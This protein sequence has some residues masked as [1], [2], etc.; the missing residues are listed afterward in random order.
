[1][2]NST[3]EVNAVEAA[4]GVFTNFLWFPFGSIASSTV[5]DWLSRG[6]SIGI[7]FDDTAEQDSSGVGGSQ[8]TWNGMQSVIGNAISS[9]GSTFPSAPAPVTTRDHFLIWVS[10]AADGPA[11]QTAQAKL[12][13]NAGI[14]LDTSYSTFPKR[15]GYMTGSGL[16]MKFL[17]TKTG[18]VIPVYEQATQYEDDI[19]LLNT[20]Y[21]LNWNLATAQ[22]HFQQSLS[23]SFNKYNTV[24]TMLFH[25]DEWIANNHQAFAAPVLQYA[26]AQSIPMPGTAAWLAFWQGRASNR[27]IHAFVQFQHLV[28]Y[29]DGL[30]SRPYASDARRVG[31]K[32]RFC[33]HS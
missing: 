16:P 28:F 15:W 12:L 11:D 32:H 24:V 14:Q 20:S 30:S 18:A 23:D 31:S 17:D 7:H 8:A 1:M 19:Q 22:A 5:S 26:Q 10:N 29:C 27:S 2:E 9:F 4:G 25:P 6:N 21:G 3:S 33:D 13:Q